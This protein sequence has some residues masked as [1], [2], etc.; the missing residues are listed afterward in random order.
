MSPLQTMSP[1][2]RRSGLMIEGTLDLVTGLPPSNTEVDW[3]C[4]LAFENIAA[5]L[6]EAHGIKRL[7]FETHLVV[8]VRPGTPARI[9]ELADRL[10]IIHQIPFLYQNGIEVGVNGHDAE[11]VVDFHHTPV[12]A[13]PTGEHHPARGGRHDLRADRIHQIQAF[14]DR[15]LAVHRV[16]PLAETAGDI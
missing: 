2:I 15:G 7:A 10:A 12:A 14:V 9:A 11:A 5:C 1:L 16:G 4:L 6:Q 3:P 13:A 8:D